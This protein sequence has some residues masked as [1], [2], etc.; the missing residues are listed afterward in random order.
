M[1]E[2]RWTFNDLFGHVRMTPMYQA[3]YGEQLPP[4][5]YERFDRDGV[6]VE[7][8]IVPPAVQIVYGDEAEA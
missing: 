7:Q 8:R 4:T 5:L 2:Q 1:S 3:I 6:C